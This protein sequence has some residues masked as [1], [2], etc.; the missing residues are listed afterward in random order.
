MSDTTITLTDCSELRQTLLA[1]P[2]QSILDTGYLLTALTIAIFCWEAWTP[3]EIVVRAT[4]RVRPV[5]DT[6]HVFTSTGSEFDGRVKAVH[7]LE[8]GKVQKGQVLIELDSQRI[9]LA[10][11]EA[12]SRVDSAKREIQQ[13]D[14]RIR[15]LE[16]QREASVAEARVELAEAEQRLEKTRARRDSL[17]RQEQAAIELAEDNHN[18][19]LK[20]LAQNVIGSQ[21]AA[22][23]EAALSKA[24]ESLQQALLPLDDGQVN[25]LKA[26]VTA[27][28]HDY[29]ARVAQLEHDRIIK[30]GVVQVSERHLEKLQLALDRQILKAPTNGVVISRKINVGDELEAGAAVIEL[31]P[32]AHS[33]FEAEVPSE[34]VG[35]LRV[36]MEVNL[37][38]DAYDYQEYGTVAGR[39]SFIAPDSHMPANVTGSSMAHYRVRIELKEQSFRQ[40]GKQAEVSL[41]MTGVAEFVTE[42]KSILEIILRKIRGSISFG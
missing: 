41:G 38:L 2:H 6:T 16:N 40:R 35:N 24:Q 39:V 13:L 18:R 14:T 5:D 9:N 33:V 25:V 32:G 31:A 42:R 10:I 20:L 15:L 23:S 34:E 36:G 17:I 11:A 3:A 29:A 37:K 30:Q 19:V 22:T 4:G 8:G 26:S 1:K 28:E 21:E 27:I 7:F 12:G